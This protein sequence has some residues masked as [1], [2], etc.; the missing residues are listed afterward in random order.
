MSVLV[1]I[2]NNEGKVK[3]SSLEAVCFASK[4]GGDVIAISIGNIDTSELEK[5]GNY[6]VVKVLNANVSKYEKPSI[7]AYSSLIADAS[8]NTGASTLVMAKS[9][10]GDAMAGR[11]AI[12]LDAS[13]AQNVVAQPEGNTVKTSIFSGKAFANVTLAK[14]NKIFA[15]KKG[16]AELHEKGGGAAIVE[17]FSGNVSDSDFS[18]ET[19]NVE[20]QKGKILLPD[21]ELVVSAGR[22]L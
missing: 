19:I 2:E 17:T 16:A 10:I 1:Y 18:V 15:L 22:G 7:Q 3:K 21:A 8:K 12:K 4:L 14:E 9:A 6:G 11:L 20:K 5:L 13:L